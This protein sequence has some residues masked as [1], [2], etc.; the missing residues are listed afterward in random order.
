MVHHP[1]DDVLGAAPARI[2]EALGDSVKG[3]RTRNDE[4]SLREIHYRR[5]V[6]VNRV[7]KGQKRPDARVTQNKLVNPSQRW[8]LPHPLRKSIF[9]HLPEQREMI[10]MFSFV[11]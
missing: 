8:C 2:G 7:L 1:V 10:A 9:H 5:V 4:L 6:Q 11:T 3:S